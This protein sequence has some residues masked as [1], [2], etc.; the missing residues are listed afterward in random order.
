MSTVLVTGAT[1]FIGRR[2]VPALID[3]GHEVCAMTRHPETYDGPGEA[4][5]PSSRLGDTSTA[6]T[7]VVTSVVLPR[8][9]VGATVALVV[10]SIAL[11][12][13]AGPLI[14]YSSDAAVELQARGPYIEAVLGGDR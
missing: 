4:V 1:G 5:G 8:S 3:A 14:E 2:L 13:L 10:F 6:A 11:T 9:M 7:P 12:V